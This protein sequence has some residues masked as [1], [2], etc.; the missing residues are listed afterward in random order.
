MSSMQPV[1][2]LSMAIGT[3]SMAGMG[4]KA[5]DESL[6]DD[7]S[8]ECNPL[9]PGPRPNAGG[10]GAE[11]LFALRDVT[12]DQGMAWRTTGWDLDDICTDAPEFETECQPPS[13]GDEIEVDGVSGTDNVVAHEVIPFAIVLGIEID[14]PFRAHMDQ[15]LGVT[16]LR[17]RGY[18]GSGNDDRVE[19]TFAPAAFGT[20]P[21]ADGSAPAPPTD[22]TL[23]PPPAWDGQDYFWADEAAFVGGDPESPMIRDDNAYVVDGLLVARPTDRASFFLTAEGRTLEVI[24]SGALL[25]GRFA[26][27]GQSLE[28]VVLAGRW[29]R[30]DLVA[31]LGGLDICPGTSPYDRM[32]RLLELQSDIRVTAGSGG[33]TVSCDAL[34]VAIGFSG[35]GARL[36]GLAPALPRP[37]NCE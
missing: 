12:L 18:D 24:L 37:V 6:L 35:Q 19:V 8:A 10:D 7:A 34:S 5:F 25:T 4:C 17:V 13:A 23:P 20:T 30:N 31:T 11:Q 14:P 16:L 26:A 1:L 22:G 21:L 3:F 29:D 36:A 27:D 15:S 2:A 32:L 33:P 9:H 28:D